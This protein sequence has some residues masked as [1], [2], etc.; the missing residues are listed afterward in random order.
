MKQFLLLGIALI[1]V[2]AVLL[3]SPK[4]GI[5][6]SVKESFD[7]RQEKRTVAVEDS[8]YAQQTNHMVKPAEF[9]TTPPEGTVSAYRVN[10]YHAYL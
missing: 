7:T 9:V 1:V 3:Y 2:F 4:A 6:G 10:N 8:S 5:P